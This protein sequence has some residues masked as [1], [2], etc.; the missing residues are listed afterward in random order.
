MYA[1][2]HKYRLLYKM[3]IKTIILTDKSNVTKY[4]F[5]IIVYNIPFQYE[6]NVYT[7]TNVKQ[8]RIFR[9]HCF[10]RCRTEYA[11]NGNQIF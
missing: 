3:K 10:G 1:N 11:G 6:F 8:H 9:R 5:V 7:Q 4:F 2:R